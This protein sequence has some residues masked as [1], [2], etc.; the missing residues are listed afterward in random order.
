MVIL[1]VVFT[2]DSE[3]VSN[4]LLYTTFLSSVFS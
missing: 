4:V 3:N 1:K 2:A